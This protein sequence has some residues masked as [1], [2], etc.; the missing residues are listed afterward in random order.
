MKLIVC[1][2]DR[3]GMLFNDRRQSKD[4]ILRQKILGLVGENKLWMNGYS[5]RQFSQDAGNI[6][7]DEDFLERAACEDYCF[8]ENTDIAPYAARID[9][10]VIYRW[11]RVYPSNVKFPTEI[12]EGRWERMESCDFSGSSHEKIT[13]EVY[14]L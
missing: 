11:N 2:D 5:A 6:I 9:T 8:V 14:R 4:R 12:F 13:Q 3:N 10:V 1:L 7:V